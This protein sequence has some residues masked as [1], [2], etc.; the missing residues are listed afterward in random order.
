MPF[1]NE[2]TKSEPVVGVYWGT[3]D[4]PTLA[5]GNIV[6][7]AFKQLKLTKL[8][9]VINNN[10]KTGK[11]YTIPIDERK[12]M[13]REMLCAE[14]KNEECIKHFAVFSQTDN[15]DFSYSKIKELS[16]YQKIIAI[17][18]QD[19]FDAY[20]KYISAYDMV[21]IMPRGNQHD[22]LDAEIQ[23]LGLTNIVIL[24]T[25]KSFLGVSSTKVREAVKNNDIDYLTN[26]SAPRVKKSILTRGF[27]KPGY[28][29][30]QY[31]AVHHR[32]AEIIQRVWRRKR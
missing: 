8:I 4:P 11:T 28:H 18:G 12:K 10:S 1:P 29:G 22:L 26:A 23:K 20:K 13:F 15:F 2:E 19:S 9:I 25:D 7:T 16:I 30:G 31:T 32:S 6:K 24:K 17:V 14:Y 5:H 21:A 27:F 3:F